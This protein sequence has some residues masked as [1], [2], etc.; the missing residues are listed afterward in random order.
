MVKGH[1]FSTSNFNLDLSA[2]KLKWLK[3]ELLKLSNMEIDELVF[4]VKIDK[5]IENMKSFKEQTEYSGH[6]SVG[7]TML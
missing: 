7:K 6:K 5:Y 2:S 3:T 1:Y 4:S